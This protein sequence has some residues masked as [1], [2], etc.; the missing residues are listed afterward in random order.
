MPSADPSH[1]HDV[2]EHAN[3]GTDQWVEDSVLPG[4]QVLRIPLVE[5]NPLPGEPEGVPVSA[6]LVRQ[7]TAKHPRAV[8]YVHGWS[9]YFFQT[10]MAEFFDQLGYDFHAVELRRYG[11]SLAE[12]ML[13]G[14]TDDVH[15]YFEELDLALAVIR[16]E[17]DQVTLM[18]HST[19]GLVAS[20]WANERPGA[21]HGLLLNSPWLDWQGT[22]LGRMAT[23]A[24]A[25]PLGLRPRAATATIPL[26]DSGHYLRSIHASL[27]GEWDFDIGLKRH[28][29]FTL[30]PGW[31]RAVL[32]GHREV[33]AGL[34]IDAPVLVMLSARSCFA[35]TW[36][37]E[38]LQSDTVLNVDA[39]ARRAVQ[40]GDNVT[41]MRFDGG[42]HDLVLSRREVRDRVYAVME[43][44]MAAW[45]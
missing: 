40:L 38:H 19:G 8:L 14:Y 3:T 45:L 16:R 30:R 10:E 23:E 41:V 2:D 39:L 13:G 17:H 24:L 36:S 31:L 12:G 34:A 33:R 5:H 6:T 18:G 29:S 26:P 43:R 22:P 28:P 35:R 42:L 37:P 32:N 7:H 21:F 4:Y 11:R 9:D 27:D 25:V 44:W 20:L 1:T 15:Q